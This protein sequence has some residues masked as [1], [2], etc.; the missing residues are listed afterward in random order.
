MR[1]LATVSALAVLG[2]VN[3]QL[4]SHFAISLNIGMTTDQ[5]I[6]FIAILE[7]HCGTEIATNARAV[8]DECRL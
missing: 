3:S 5:L 6:E 4:K 8:L 1:E 2:G 7:Q